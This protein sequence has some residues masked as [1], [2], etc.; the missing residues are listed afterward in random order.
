MVERF[1]AAL[2]HMT[3]ALPSTHTK[4]IVWN[5][6]LRERKSPLVA[7]IRPG[8]QKRPQT[9]FAA[10][11]ASLIRTAHAR[12]ANHSPHSPQ[13]QTPESIHSTPA[14]RW[15]HRAERINQPRTPAGFVFGSC[16]REQGAQGQSVS[17]PLSTTTHLDA[18]AANRDAPG[19]AARN[20][21]DKLAPSSTQQ[22]RGMRAAGRRHEFCAER[23]RS[24]AM[25]QSIRA[26]VP[27][28]AGECA[29][30]PPRSS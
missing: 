15:T 12:K 6:A 30:R 23:G 4:T 27:L 24:G 25:L 8:A 14:G 13:S 11:L 10:A 20:K 28:L 3:A 5:L 1:D 22:A 7:L 9:L 2:K 19:T 29:P 16:D 17:G 26:Q 21:V 18:P